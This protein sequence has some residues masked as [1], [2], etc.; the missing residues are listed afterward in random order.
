MTGDTGAYVLGRTVAGGSD[1]L[2]QW[3]L[4]RQSQSFDAVF[5]P[6]GVPLAIHVDR[7]LA[8][9]FNPHGRR[10]SHAAPTADARHARLD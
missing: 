10:L 6:A 8:I 5:V 3:L 2:A 1:E 9:D 4:E 7:E